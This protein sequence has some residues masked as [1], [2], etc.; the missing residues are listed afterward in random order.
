M[1]VTKGLAATS[2]HG[3]SVQLRVQEPAASDKP[4]C[5]NAKLACPVD[6][7]RIERRRIE[8]ILVHRKH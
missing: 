1:T 6:Q 5:G 2:L 3:I 4:V 8:T 7:V